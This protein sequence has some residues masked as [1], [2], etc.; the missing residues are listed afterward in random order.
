MNLTK[1]AILAC[2]LTIA[3]AGSSGEAAAQSKVTFASAQN[4]LGSMA[5]FIARD[6]GFFAAEGITPEIIDFKGGAPAVQ[7]LAGG[8]ADLC[9]C[10][11]DHAVRLRSRGLPARVLT[12]LSEYHGYGLVTR[13]DSPATDLRS[14]KG[15]PIGITSPGSMTDNTVRFFLKKADI[16]PDRDAQLIAAGTGASMGAAIDTGSVAAGMLT[17][18]DVQAFLAMKGKYKLV[19]DYRA[20]RYSSLDLLVMEKWMKEHDAA[21]RGVAKAIVRAQGLIKSDP[22]LVTATIKTMFPNFDDALVAELTQEAPRTLSTD[23]RLNEEGYD[24]LLEMVRTADPS[25]QAVSYA[26]IV[27]LDYLPPAK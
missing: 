11:A 8:G 10:A 18:P 13:A 22:A 3:L 25:L 6:K 24:N 5:I 27:A 7:A 12:A 9:I 16:N 4:S 26:D 15:K 1:P 23:G 14:L 20:L 17:T 2:L 21:A 19:E